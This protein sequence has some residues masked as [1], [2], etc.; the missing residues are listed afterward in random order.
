MWLVAKITGVR[1]QIP[2]RSLM[3]QACH[4]NA[5]A[6]SDFELDLLFSL[7]WNAAAVLR[8]HGLLC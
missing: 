8:L 1:T 4:L 6:I 7:N 2:N 3:S 5:T